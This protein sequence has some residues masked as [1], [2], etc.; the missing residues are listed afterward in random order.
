MWG[1]GR[2]AHGPIWPFHWAFSQGQR[3]HAF[4]RDAAGLRLDGAGLRP[5][6][7]A[8]G[9]ME[10]RLRFRC[11][12]PADDSRFERIALVLQR[13]LA[14]IQVDLEL[15][16]VP[17][18]TLFASVVTG[19]FDAFLYEMSSGRTLSWVNRFWH[20]PSAETTTV[21]DAGYRAADEPLDRIRAAASDAEFRA[22]VADLQQVFYE[23]P[24]AV[25]LAWPHDTRAIDR[26]FSV[27]YEPDRDVLGSLWQARRS[28]DTASDD[29]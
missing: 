7:P 5:E 15:V 22:A 9:G 24:P 18:R 3:V 29:R 19:K 1:R 17:V 26:S 10:S 28:S 20:S 8:A 12:I 23:D 13:Q 11:L 27:P 14:E 16:P 6:R 4:N 21:F 25:F 2:P